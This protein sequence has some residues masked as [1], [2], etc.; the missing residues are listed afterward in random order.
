MVMKQKKVKKEKMEFTGMVT[1]ANKSIFQ[2]DIGNGKTV[3][4]TLSGKIRTNSIRILV[5]DKVLIE[6]SEYDPSK[7]RITVRY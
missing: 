2:I 6:V 4:C 5:G 3:Q 1:D 7:G